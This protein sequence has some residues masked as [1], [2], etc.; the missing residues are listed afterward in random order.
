MGAGVAGAIKRRGGDEIE[1]EAMR[2]GPVE[3]GECVLTSGG[4]LTARHVVHAAVMGQ[5]LVTSAS[6]IEHATQKA[7]RLAE[8][9][10]LAS[11]EFSALGTEDGGFAIE[12]CV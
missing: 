8:E 6:Y 1:A 7:M 9:R 11:I 10:M 2:Q 12:A 4:R 5:D 3:P